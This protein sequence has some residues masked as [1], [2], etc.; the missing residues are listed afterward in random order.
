MSIQG[1]AAEA[2]VAVA[3]AALSAARAVPAV[4]AVA[5]SRVD[6]KARIFLLFIAVSL[7]SFMAQAEDRMI[8][9]PPASVFIL[10]RTGFLP[11]K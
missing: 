9:R 5:S 7:S 11:P 3:G 8:Q 10:K 4:R 2:V 1:R 6:M